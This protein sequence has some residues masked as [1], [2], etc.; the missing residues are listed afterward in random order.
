MEA[1]IAFFEMGL[2]TVHDTGV[3]CDRLSRQRLRRL[4][5]MKDG[6]MMAKM[7][8]EVAG[9]KNGAEGAMEEFEVG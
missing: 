2:H 3:A 7:L 9:L 8:V 1:G 4:R 5:R 6:A